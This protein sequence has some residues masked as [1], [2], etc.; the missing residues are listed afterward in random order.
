MPKYQSLFEMEQENPD[1]FKNP[2][3][4]DADFDAMMA[5]NRA[6]AAIE[7]ANAEASASNAEND[8]DDENEEDDHDAG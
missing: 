7:D 8:E 5:R 1:V 4:S 2:P 6:R 3:I